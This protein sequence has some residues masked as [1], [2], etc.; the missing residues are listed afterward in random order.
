MFLI[1]A[2]VNFRR[3]SYPLSFI[4]DVSALVLLRICWLLNTMSIT[5]KPMI[6]TPISSF[7]ESSIYMSSNSKVSTSSE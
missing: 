5:Y 4:I 7:D 3:L 1:I 2:T 6:F